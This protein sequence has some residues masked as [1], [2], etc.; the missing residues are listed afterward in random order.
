MQ[1]GFTKS[2]SSNSGNG[3]TFN[4]KSS[5]D[6]SS[7]FGS[8]SNS[9]VQNSQMAN[10]SGQRWDGTDGS[11][12][13]TYGMNSGEGCP[14]LEAIRAQ[15]AKSRSLFEDT[16]FP[17]D[18]K[19]IFVN[20]TPRSVPVT[21]FRA[22]EIARRHRFSPAFNTSAVVP[23]QHLNMVRGPLGDRWV[24]AALAVIS[25]YPDLLRAIVP[26]GQ[27]FAD[28]Y[29]G[30][31]SFR[32]WRMGLWREVVV[33]DRLPV[34]SSGELLCLQA[35]DD[36]MAA[37]LEK[38]YAKFCGSYEALKSLSIADVLAELTGGMME[39]FELKSLSNNADVAAELNNVLFKAFERQ[40]L[41]GAATASQYPRAEGELPSGLLSCHTYSVTDIKEI[42]LIQQ[43]ERGAPGGDQQSVTL[44][45]V[46][47]QMGR[48]SWRGDWSEGSAQWVALLPP[49]REAMGLVLDDEAEFW[50]DLRDLLAQFELLFLCHLPSLPAPQSQ[51]PASPL[52]NAFELPGAWI[53]HVSAGGSRKFL[54]MTH[55]SP[56]KSNH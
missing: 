11:P 6:T 4:Q 20:S 10:G 9:Y 22:P 1:S 50:I 55:C 3:F 48:A 42:R 34:D 24:F 41:V 30:A 25:E 16:Q 51:P 31:F 54:G 8:R 43:V 44:L 52:W 39:L 19:S 27:G 36:F 7:G 21:W 26:E 49:D 56:I 33:D 28:Q 12:N 37:L 40:S 13:S 46:R 18:M 53:R 23:G 2:P 14:A 15:C 47:N 45:R 5:L 32:F 38:A 17:A 35:G 29:C